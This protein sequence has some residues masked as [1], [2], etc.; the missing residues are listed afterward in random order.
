MND[1][2]RTTPE[3]RSKPQAVEGQQV[4][5]NPYRTAVE[6]TL[7][8]HEI[9]DVGRL[10]RKGIEV[11]L[12]VLGPCE[13]VLFLLRGEAL[14]PHSFGRVPDDLPEQP[15]VLSAVRKA[16]ESGTPV[17]DGKGADRR[18]VVPVIHG[19]QSEGA[20][21]VGVAELESRWGPSYLDILNLV[22]RHLGLAIQNARKVADLSATASG[23]GLG[24]AS[25]L[26]DA[27]RE[28]ERR[29]LMARL[30]ASRGNI[31]SAARS[32]EMDRG[33]LSRLLKRHGV[34]KKQFK[35]QAD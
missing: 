10:P 8:I 25:S 18:V 11:V 27:K 26:R 22:T 9:L 21:L 1:E 20:L 6:A 28:F 29:L 2:L 34:D 31:A 14:E 5:A 3:L 33:Q 35:G 15:A 23:E 32:L 12:S 17:L 7:W 24:A 30:K 19:L 16:M 13:G 4:R